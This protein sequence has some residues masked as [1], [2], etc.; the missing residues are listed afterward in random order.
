VTI[1]ANAGVSGSSGTI[2]VPS[3]NGTFLTTNTS[4]ATSAINIATSASNYPINLKPHG[5]GHVVVGNAGATGKL[6][7]NGAYDLVIDT[8][9][10]TNAGNITLT[11]ASDGAITVTPNGS[12]VFTIGGA[13]TAA[14]QTCAN[15]GSVTTADI[16]GGTLGGI[17][18]DGNWTA[19]S[20][21]CANLGTVTTADINGGTIDG[22]TVGASSHTTGK[23]TTCDATTDFT[24]GG[25]VITDNTITDD[26]TLI[27]AASTA[28]SF[29]DG[30][31]THVGDL[32]C[33]SISVD[34]A[35]VGL[36][37]VF[38]GNTTL[39]KLSLTDNLADA[40]NINEGGT[41]Y[42]QFV[43]TDSG[44]KIVAGKDLETATN[45]N[46]VERGSCFHSS[47]NRSLVF[48]Y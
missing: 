1:A 2:Y 46:F 45:T 34:D 15:L 32:N 48:G 39:N 25:L 27:I 23:F 21:T 19:A 29:S 42:L 47:T 28:T 41:S 38:G 16:N 3:E 22:T 40:L 35:S 7:S 4:Y 31:I 30:N 6:T 10:G 12:G 9:S 24:I 13:W 11:N 5:T 17:T 14:S 43:T 37:L 20:Q 36:D 33:D 18:I 8:N 26:G 44:E